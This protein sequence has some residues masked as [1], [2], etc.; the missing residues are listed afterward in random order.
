MFERLCW[1][2]RRWLG[3]LVGVT[4]QSTLWYDRAYNDVLYFC[5]KCGPL[6]TVD[7]HDP[8]KDIS[9]K[10]AQVSFTVDALK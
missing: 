5:E 2:S 6:E 8:N 3:A 9:V 4:F 10:D 1:T 7:K